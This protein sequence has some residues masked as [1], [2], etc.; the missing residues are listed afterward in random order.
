VLSSGRTSSASFRFP[1]YQQ[2][3]QELG[4]CKAWRLRLVYHEPL[5][6]LGT[7]K[8]LG[9]YQ[10]GQ[11]FFGYQQ[12]LQ[13]LDTCKTQRGGTCHSLPSINCHCKGFV[14]A[15][16]FRTLQRTELAYKQ[17]LQRLGICKVGINS[18]D[19]INVWSVSSHCKGLIFASHSARVSRCSWVS[20][21]IA[22]ASFL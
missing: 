19:P 16:M 10:S 18:D 3:L 4:I 9:D 21:A 1:K 11:C 20:P 22:R 12:S 2:P 7:C 8:V 14:L 6:G 13:G 5:Q 17:P 15:R